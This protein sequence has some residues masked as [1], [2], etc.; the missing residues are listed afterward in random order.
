MKWEFES[1]V[2]KCNSSNANCKARH[3]RL[4]FL[5]RKKKQKAK[6]KTKKNK[7]V[8]LN[9]RIIIG[10]FV[11]MWEIYHAYSLTDWLITA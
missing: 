1:V 9:A 11:V 8:S 4:R 6:K 3:A 7:S 10:Y 5:E 2:S